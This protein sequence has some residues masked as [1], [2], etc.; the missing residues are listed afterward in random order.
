MTNE[1]ID[2]GL[3][4]IFRN[5]FGDDTLVLRQGMTSDD[6]PGWDSMKM[7]TIIIAVEQRFGVHL[8][9]KEIDKLTCVGD[10]AA[11]LQAKV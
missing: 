9:S 2:A 10:L 3:T 5:A 8:R 4:D 1:D 6:I 7:V 11:L